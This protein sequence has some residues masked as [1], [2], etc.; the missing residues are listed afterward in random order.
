MIRSIR[1][2]LGGLLAQ[3]A[4][5][6]PDTLGK[7]V[8]LKGHPYFLPCLSAGVIAITMFLGALI[9]LKEVLTRYIPS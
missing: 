6:W 9:G 2:I 4:V 7:I 1:P 5:R 8:Y 3:P